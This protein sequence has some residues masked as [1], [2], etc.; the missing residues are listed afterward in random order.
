MTHKA[1][2]TQHTA[3]TCTINH[4]LCQPLSRQVSAVNQSLLQNNVTQCTNCITDL[5]WN[6]FVLTH[7]LHR[8]AMLAL[9]ALY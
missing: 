5:S 3:S 1:T 7:F 8:A 6:V 9:Q 4:T 2:A